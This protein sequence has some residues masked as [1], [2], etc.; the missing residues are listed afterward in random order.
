MYEYPKLV[1]VDKDEAI[2]LGTVSF[3]DDIDLHIIVEDFEFGEDIP[4][5]FFAD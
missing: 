5:F 3:G 1:E 4:F 2:I